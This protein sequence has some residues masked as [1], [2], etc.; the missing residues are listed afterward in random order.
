[1]DSSHIRSA[2]AILSDSCSR[3][4][5]DRNH[6]IACIGFIAHIDVEAEKRQHYPRVDLFASY[7][8]A[9]R[10][11]T[12]DPKGQDEPEEGGVFKVMRYNY[13]KSGH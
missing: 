10:T 9:Y 4:A 12:F 5:V 8:F 13:G 7:L 2:S 1:M 6:C 3:S 11:K